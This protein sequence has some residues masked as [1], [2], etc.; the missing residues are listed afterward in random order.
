[1]LEVLNEASSS[2]ADLMIK[3]EY[4]GPFGFDIDKEERLKLIKLGEDE[5]RKMIPLL[6]S[7]IKSY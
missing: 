7:L 1:M 5:T 3:P 4:R 6:R 2:K